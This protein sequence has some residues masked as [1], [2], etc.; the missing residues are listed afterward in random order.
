MVHRRSFSMW[1]LMSI[2]VLQAVAF[3]GCMNYDHTQSNDGGLFNGKA[4]PKQRRRLN[5]TNN[6][7][8][9]S[10]VLLPNR[11]HHKS[12]AIALTYNTR[13]NSLP[14]HHNHNHRYATSDN[15]QNTIAN[16]RISNPF[17][18]S[19]PNG[20]SISNLSRVAQTH[21]NL[22][23]RQNSIKD[24][25]ENTSSMVHHQTRN[26]QAFRHR[27][28]NPNIQVQ[29]T[30]NRNINSGSK[31][32]YAAHSTN[33]N[34]NTNSHQR[35]DNTV[36]NPNRHSNYNF[37]PGAM[38]S[39]AITNPTT[40]AAAVD[41]DDMLDDY[42]AINESYQTLLNL[43]DPSANTN[44][45]SFN[46][47]P[48]D[49]QRSS[50][51]NPHGKSSDSNNVDL[52]LPP[53]ESRTNTH[54]STAKPSCKTNSTS[55][56]T[57]KTNATSNPSLNINPKDGGQA[58]APRSNL[59][60]NSLTHHPDSHRHT[61]T[62]SRNANYGT[63]VAIIQHSVNT[64][65]RGQNTDRKKEII[66]RTEY[67]SKIDSLAKFTCPYKLRN[68]EICAFR[69][70]PPGVPPTLYMVEELQ[71]H[72]FNWHS[73]VQVRCTRHTSDS[74]TLCVNKIRAHDSRYHT[75][76]FQGF[77]CP[78]ND[79]D[80]VESHQRFNALF[81]I[82]SSHYGGQDYVRIKWGVSLERS[83]YLINVPLT[84]PNQRIQCYGD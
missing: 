28:S 1:M 36:A 18:N 3:V 62:H 47:Y 31:I 50:S 6:N 78:F 84:N 79:C 73:R 13:S 39:V 11:N 35:I 34:T 58:D 7:P 69:G 52:P 21:I 23:G 60:H 53:L 8:R 75:Y 64:G 32:G 54:E 57:Y 71:R 48:N 5:G 22:H 56:N 59:N 29:S 67:N 76:E 41:I 51:I 20:V 16:S 19:Q 27:L 37:Q 80:F 63:H 26:P 4:P 81:H 74:Q 72:T 15:Y 45:H 66:D 49:I 65:S 2:L 46:P 68:G 55:N 10:S 38:Q 70:L 33:T 82:L 12:T 43:I 44:V 24:Q 77:Q 14:T 61:S 42:Y 83:L 25:S 30:F 17:P 9:A 40:S